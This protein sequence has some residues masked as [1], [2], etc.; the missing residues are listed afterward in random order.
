MVVADRPAALQPHG[1]L[2]DGP[3]VAEFIQTFCRHSKG[4]LAKKLIVLRDWET[5]LL[6]EM[7]TLRPDERRQYRTALVGFP[8]KNGKS[9]KGSGIALY[10]LVAD[11]EPGAEIYSCAGDKDQARIVFNE[12]KRM[13]EMDPDLSSILTLYRDAIEHKATNSVY[14]ALSAEAALKQGF[15]PHIVI[16][17]ELHVQPNGDLWNA[18]LLGMGT[19]EQPYMIAFTTAGDD[20]D[21]LLYGLYDH[22]MK[23]QNG[24]II[25]PTFYFRWYQPSKQD[26][27]WLDQKYWY[28]ANP[29][30][31]D[32]LKLEALEHDARTTPEHEFRRYH[33]DQWTKTAEAWLPY[34]AW[35]KC[36]DLTLN[37]D[38]SL[39]LR[40]GVD[41][42]YSNDCAAIVG[43]QKQGDRT[44]I[45]LM[46]IWENPHAP[47]HSEY[48]HWK[49][50]PFEVEERLREIRANFPHPATTIDGRVMPG[51]EFSYDPAWF[52]RSAPVLEG[53]GLT[54]VEFPQT[55]S[56][57]V[58]A[59]QTLFQLVT[60]VKLAH[61]GDKTLKR[62]VENGI[63]DRR[64]RGW[65]ITKQN[66]KRKI[67]G[68]IAAA[69]AVI[70]AQEPVPV[71]KRSAYEDR[72]LVVV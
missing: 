32:F 57:M 41:M 15:N 60:E 19:R 36:E 33:L 58:P 70:R 37:L 26:C 12:A 51:P 52:S 47:T 21:S 1:R 55:D 27:D 71:R 65:R 17:D 3:R 23:I 22:G 62:H 48:V 13:V 20:E 10:G 64:P 69:I 68:L 53:D 34:G 61:D 50:N 67:D 40:V 35:D 18:M 9:L 66:A 72:G 39:P 31:G 29:A 44:V 6:D 7:F 2:T 14:R 49:I 54:M 63:V 56:R 16:F 5:D 11:G 4:A 25:D 38:P 42:A 43:A 30:L 59:A 8:R 28:E 24:E 46:G 45:R